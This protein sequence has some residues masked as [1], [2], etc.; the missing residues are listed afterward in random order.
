[1]KN[2]RFYEAEKYKTADY[3]IVDEKIYKTYENGSESDDYLGLEQL[4]D[5]ALAEKLKQVEGWEYG[6]GE[7]LEDYLILNYE[8]KK[9]YRDIEDVGTD[10]DIV[11]VNMDDPSNSP[12]EIFVTSI[13][14]EA[15]PDLGENSPSEPVISQYPLEDILDNMYICTMIM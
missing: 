4:D 7:M 3:E 14:F 15:E 13:V 11:M 2:I 12:K 5:N 6:A 10:N 9:Y 8:G 1:M